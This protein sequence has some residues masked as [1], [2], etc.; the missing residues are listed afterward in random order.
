MDRQDTSKNNVILE[1][2]TLPSH[3]RRRTSLTSRR[4]TAAP[5]LCHTRPSLG[6]RSSIVSFLFY[7]PSEVV[8]SVLHHPLSC[9]LSARR[10]IRGDDPSLLYAD[11]V[12]HYYY[13]PLATGVFLQYGV[14]P[15]TQGLN[16]YED[17]EILR[18]LHCALQPFDIT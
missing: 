18:I 17:L 16:S 2:C 6:V 7:H 13:Y 3:H 5:A 10:H 12:C 1:V 9:R 11:C 14:R 15:C 4:P 8:A